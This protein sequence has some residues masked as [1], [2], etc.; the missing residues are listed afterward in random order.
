M[1]P[2][3]CDL[4]ELR[5]LR[6]GRPVIPP[7]EPTG[8]ARPLVRADYRA[9]RRYRPQLRTGVADATLHRGELRQPPVRRAAPVKLLP[10]R[11]VAAGLVLRDVPKTTPHVEREQH[12]AP[13]V[14]LRGGQLVDLL[15]VAR[16]GPVRPHP[17][18]PFS[19]RRFLIDSVERAFK[20]DT[21]QL[22]A[23]F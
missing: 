5:F 20:I 12:D 9:V 15:R 18:A 17:I 22:C 16:P 8:L 2:C 21:P 3:C 11:P 13:V 10:P 19:S 14:L 6:R 1:L 4:Y 23:A 7:L